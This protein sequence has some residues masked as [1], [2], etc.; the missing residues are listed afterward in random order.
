MLEKR[1]QAY[2]YRKLAGEIEAKIRDGTYKVGERLPSIRK[3]QKRSHLSLTTVHQAYMELEMLGLVEARPKS[4]YYVSA[5]LLKDIKAPSPAR[6]EALPREITLSSVI[7]S[8][9][10][11]VN[12]P[13]LLPLGSSVTS[14]ELLP[15]KYFSRIMKGI[16][17]REMKDLISYSLTEG[18][19][20]LRRQIALRTTGLLDEISPED[21]VITNGCMEAVAL[22][23]QALTRTGDTVAIETPTHFAFLQLLKELGLMVVEAP[24][25]PRYG[26]D[27]AEM[28]HIIQ[29]HD[30]KACL[31]M[32]NFHNPL[33]ALMPD[34]RKAELVRLLNRHDVPI[35][36]DDLSSELHFDEQRPLPLKAFDRKGLVL[37]CSSFSKTLAPGF[38]M[39]WLIPGRRFKEKILSLKAGITIAS[40]TLDQYLVAQYLAAGAYDRHLR[41]LRRTIL[42][43]LAK[44]AQAV[45][46]YFP[47]GARMAFPRGGPL[48]WIELDRNVD[49][50][51]VYQAALDRKISILPGVVCSSSGGFG[52]YI[53]LGCGF[54]YTQATESGLGILGEI[55]SGVR[56]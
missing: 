56:V 12:N 43:H 27:V 37:T 24:T 23:L 8:V 55:I 6:A 22:S 19:P 54:P 38:R 36:E 5:P 17:S 46:R 30:I 40:S 45:Q 48:L 14:S 39:G 32:P 47:A 34:E 1:K 20:E 44:T 15:Y 11:A 2:R 53:R 35:I 49:G 4:G 29:R 31:F 7:N 26:V 42:K 9:V 33:G 18:T 25:D 10:T 21:V 52:N 3:L 51:T 13:D 41:R 50:L 28:A 16:S